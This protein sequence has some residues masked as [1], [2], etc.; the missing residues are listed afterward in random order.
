[1]SNKDAKDTKATKD[2]KR[3]KRANRDGSGDAIFFTSTG[4]VPGPGDAYFQGDNIDFCSGSDPLND[5]YHSLIVANGTRVNCW[6]HC[7]GTGQFRTY[8]DGPHDDISDIGGLSKFQVLPMES[9]YAIGLK[10]TDGTGLGHPPGFYEMTFVAHDIGDAG[11]P[12]GAEDY[13]Y[14]PSSSSEAVL[15]CA[16]YVRNL[17]SGVYVATGSVYLQW[18]HETGIISIDDQEE[19]FPSNMSVTQDDNTHFTF[20]L[21]SENA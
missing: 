8:T 16:I 13:V 21:N 19:T 2:L 6:Q 5:E 7:N 10:L 15:T 20:T 9:S 1:M 17:Q 18:D 3:S 11:V 12:S 4:L 14:L